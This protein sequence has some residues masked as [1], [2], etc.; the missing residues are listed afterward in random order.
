MDAEKLT[1]NRERY[2]A[3]VEDAL[4]LALERNEKYGNSIDLARSDS[5]VDLC[6]MKLYR[7]R[8]IPPGDSKK[9]D[10]LVDCLNYIVFILMR[11]Y[12]YDGNETVTITTPD[13][14]DFEYRGGTK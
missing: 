13:T 4:K 7:T 8:H 10:E 5:I 9:Y 2:M 12:S 6:L 1:V 14:L 3:V 11:E